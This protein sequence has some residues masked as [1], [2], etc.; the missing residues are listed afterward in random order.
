MYLTII[1]L[2]YRHEQQIMTPMNKEITTNPLLGLIG[3][4]QGNK[5][6][7][8][9]PKPE[10]D[11][12]NPYYETLIIES[13]DGDL[14]NAEEEEL[15]A[16]RYSQVVREISNDKVSHTET[17]FWIWNKNENTIMCTLSIPRGLSLV[18]GGEIKTTANNELVFNVSAQ[19]DNSE[20]GIVQSPF[21]KKKAKTLDF[22]RE[23]ILSGNTLSYTQEMTL[24]IYSKTFDHIDKNTLTKTSS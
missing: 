5:G 3:T 22:K 7:D 21:L 15:S 19:A 23:M 13:I 18:A 12:N 8:L 20:W 16:V 1:I 9:A 2:A 4:W 6:I 11:E 10:E 17:G 24:D 14:E